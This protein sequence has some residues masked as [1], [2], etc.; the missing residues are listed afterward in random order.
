MVELNQDLMQKNLSC[1]TIGEAQKN[2]F[3]FTR[4]FIAITIAFLSV[5]AF[6][7]LTLIPSLVFLLGLIAATFATTDSALTAITISF[8]IDF[9]GMDKSENR[10]KLTAIRDRQLTHLGFCF[11]YF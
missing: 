2:M 3:A 6:R 11:L 4:I 1:A 9:L 8:C 7:H 10:I 5:G